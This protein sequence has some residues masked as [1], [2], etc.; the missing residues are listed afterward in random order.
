MKHTYVICRI[1]KEDSEAKLEAGPFEIESKFSNPKDLPF[2][3]FPKENAIYKLHEN[4]LDVEKIQLTDKIK[5]NAYKNKLPSPEETINSMDLDLSTENLYMLYSIT[6]KLKVLSLTDNSTS[7]QIDFKS[8]SDIPYKYP[9]TVK[10]FPNE[11]YLVFRSGGKK[12]IFITF[13]LFYKQFFT[14][15]QLIPL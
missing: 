9:I 12:Y 4:R 10:V 7:S 5:S 2:N 14:L 13:V 15:L 3:Y 11:K 6:A 1:G 8:R